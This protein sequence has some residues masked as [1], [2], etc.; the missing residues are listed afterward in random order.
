MPKNEKSESKASFQSF[1]DEQMRDPEFRRA[2]DALEPEFQI[3][4]QIIDLRLKRKMT[5]TELARRIGAAQPSIARMERRG[6]TRDLDYLQ[7]VANALDATLEVRL[8]PREASAGKGNGRR[9]K[10]A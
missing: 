7:R 5:Q 3:M 9:A 4:R 1:L 8:V 2:Y 10:R 6:K